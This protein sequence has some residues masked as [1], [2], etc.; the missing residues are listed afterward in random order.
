MKSKRRV[1]NAG[2]TAWQ[3]ISPG[4]HRLAQC[5][6]LCREAFGF[7]NCVAR[8]AGRIRTQKIE[9]IVKPSLGYFC[10]VIL[11]TGLS[12]SGRAGPLVVP[13][14]VARLPFCPGSI[15]PPA[16]P[17]GAR[18]PSRVGHTPR[19]PCGPYDPSPSGIRPD[20]FRTAAAA[21]SKGRSSRRVPCWCAT[22]L[23]HFSSSPRGAV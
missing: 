15:H 9:L 5:G 12:I 14:A 2:R 23:S 3:P 16:D 13:G 18:Q 11:M 1:L 8:F 19:S 20:A 10:E 7:L 22:S 21:G 4:M 17:A 6:Q